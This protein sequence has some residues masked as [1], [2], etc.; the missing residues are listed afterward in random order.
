MGG[1]GLLTIGALDSSLL[2]LP[3][4]N[5]LLIIAMSARKHLFV[6][7]YAAMAAAGSVLGCLS[8][9]YLTRR[10][11]EK[12]LEAYVSPRRLE[13]VRSRMRKNA[14]WALIIASIMPPPFP[15]TLFIGAAAAS[16]YPRRR[17][18]IT[19][20][21][22]RFVRFAIEGTLAVFVGKELLRWAQSRPF[23]YAMLGLVGIS[24][25]GSVFSIGRW[26][27]QARKSKLRS[28]RA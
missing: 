3:L 4:G 1:F 24:I 20:A 18:L 17:L 23:E 28:T 14:R 27:A 19:V 22:A 6:P 7:Y 2:F 9:D 12:E 10:G 13:Y 16:N 8:V 5:D 26:T 25:L 21:V 15:F 11:G